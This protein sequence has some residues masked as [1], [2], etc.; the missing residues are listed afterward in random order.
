[1]GFEFEKSTTRASCE[2][3]CIEISGEHS[4]W[5]MCAEKRRE[6]EVKVHDNSVGPSPR[7]LAFLSS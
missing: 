7:C 2:A 1:M 5:P 3:L 6:S 4:A